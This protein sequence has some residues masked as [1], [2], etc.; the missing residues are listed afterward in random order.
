MNIRKLFCHR[1]T[2]GVDLP[3]RGDAHIQFFRYFK[4]VYQSGYTNDL[5]HQQCMKVPVAPYFHQLGI[6][7]LFH[8]SHFGRHV[9]VIE[10]KLWFNF[11]FPDD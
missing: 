11:H 1:Y 5:F 9:M 7:C 10:L 3:G 6:A 8:S 4:I 2:K